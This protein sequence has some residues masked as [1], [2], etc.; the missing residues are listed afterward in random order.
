MINTMQKN[1]CI[2][3]IFKENWQIWVITSNV[4][5][6]INLITLRQ[7]AKTRV[8][9][10]QSQRSSLQHAKINGWLIKDMLLHVIYNISNVLYAI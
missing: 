6:Y 10:T 9:Y 1:C 4:E 7:I 5:L 2:T 3:Q 8:R